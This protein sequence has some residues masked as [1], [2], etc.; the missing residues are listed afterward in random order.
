[1]V[2]SSG[3][4]PPE[5]PGV[6]LF[7]WEAKGGVEARAR[8]LA[9][10]AGRWPR[11]RVS[12]DTVHPPDHQPDRPSLDRCVQTA[13][14]SFLVRARKQNLLLLLDLGLVVQ[15]LQLRAVPLRCMEISLEN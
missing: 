6:Q 11:L 15:L 3:L 2:E 9:A 1:M 5:R 10:A 13:P 14:L 7:A 8:H 4:R 12:I